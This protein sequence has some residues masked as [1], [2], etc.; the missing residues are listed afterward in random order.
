MNGSVCIL[1]DVSCRK[2]IKGGIIMCVSKS[3]QIH[4]SYNQSHTRI[5]HT[6]VSTHIT[7]TL[8]Q[9]PNDKETPTKNP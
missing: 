6:H 2:E 3:K 4:P 5:I 7:C 1:C 9:Q 8:N